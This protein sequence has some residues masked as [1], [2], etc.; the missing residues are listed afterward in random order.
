MT[1]ARHVW[2]CFL[3][4]IVSRAVSLYLVALAGAGQH[5]MQLAIKGLGM[6]ERRGALLR[7]FVELQVVQGRQDDIPNT[8][9]SKAADCRESIWLAPHHCF[10]QEVLHLGSALATRCLKTSDRIYLY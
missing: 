2:P 7:H 9:K 10:T 6:Y 8:R 3:I 1:V 4:S 5:S